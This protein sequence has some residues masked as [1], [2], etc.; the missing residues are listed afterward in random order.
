MLSHLSQN[1]EIRH[2]KNTITYVLDVK[3]DKEQISDA[4]KNILTAFLK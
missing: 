4:L 1:V 3:I 2:S